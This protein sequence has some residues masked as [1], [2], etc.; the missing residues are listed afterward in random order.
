[1]KRTSIA[2]SMLLAVASPLFSTAQKA[3]IQQQQPRTLQPNEFATNLPGATHIVAPPAEFDAINASDSDLAYHGFPPRPDQTSAPKAYASWTRA[4]KASKSRV[5]PNLE[6]TKVFHGPAKVNGSANAPA[7]G[8]NSLS[9]Y[10]WSG[11]V[12]FSGA[13]A[14]SS[15]SYYY[16]YSDF[17]VPVARQPFGTCTG[18]WDW[19]STWVGIDGWGSS[20]VLQAGVEFDAYCSI[21]SSAPY[22]SP[23]YEWFPYGETRITNL[24]I[25]PGD[26]YFVE[27]WSTSATQ[28]YA[29]LVNEN[30]NQAVSIGFTAPAGTR[31]V[32]NSAE[33]ITERPGVGGSLASLTNYV[34]DPYWSSYA[35]TFGYNVTDPSSA[36]SYAI[37][38]L[39][40]AGHPDSYP[41]LLGPAAFV[42]QTEGSAW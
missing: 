40:N 19:G 23:W 37:V 31:L 3:E 9:S 38:G 25:A 16:V 5:A 17:I 11:Y 1:M 22:Y 20:D 18:G 10:N 21:F 24:P 6:M 15:A 8:D 30:T 7:A 28:G 35:V 42:M 39:D 14:Y 36:T 34:A 2:L 27:V 4:I 33:W 13:S 29:Y 32:G 41:T 12:N 26:E